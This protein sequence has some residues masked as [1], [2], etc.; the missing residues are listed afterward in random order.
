MPKL[1]PETLEARRDHVLDAAEK[2]FA[3]NG[4][5][6]TTMQMICREAGI[7]PGALYVYFDSKESLIAGICERDRSDFSQRFAEVAQA[8]DLM[9]ALNDMAAHYFVDEAQHKLAMTV[10]IGAEAIRNENIRAMFKLCD[11]TVSENFVAL[12]SRL[13]QEGRIAPA[14]PVEKAAQLMHVIGDGLLW[15]RAIDPD[16]DAKEM[17]PSV[18]ALIGLLLAPN[19]AAMPGADDENPKSTAADL[20]DGHTTPHGPREADAS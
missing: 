6:A 10:E 19:P 4:F 3:R 7:S 5:H 11:T 9:A 13:E 12:F 8:P 15:R 14:V 1:K 20:G 2:C 18:L 16:F 17:L